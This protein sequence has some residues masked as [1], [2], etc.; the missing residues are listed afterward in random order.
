MLGPQRGLGNEHKPTHCW[1][2]QPKLGGKMLPGSAQRNGA[3]W[4]GP[5]TKLTLQEELDLI[6]PVSSLCWAWG[7]EL[8]RGH[9]YCAGSCRKRQNFAAG[10]GDGG[11]G[12]PPHGFG[13]AI[14]LFISLFQ[15][16]NQKRNKARLSQRKAVKPDSLNNSDENHNPH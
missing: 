15:A 12:S 3:F 1:R 16:G 10:T 5:R 4:L 8:E 11:P 9:G 7:C 2:E 13:E 14:S 6:H